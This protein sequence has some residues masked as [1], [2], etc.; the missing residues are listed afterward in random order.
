MLI[1]T[2]SHFLP[3]MD[4]GAKDVAESADLLQAIAAQGVTDLVS[5]AHFY[6][7]RESLDRFLER[8]AISIQELMR[9]ESITLNPP[10]SPFFAH[11]EGPSGSMR[12]HLGAEVALSSALFDQND[13][14]RL[15]IDR[16]PYMLIELPFTDRWDSNVRTQL[17]SLV[18]EYQLKPIIAHVERYP[19]SDY[20]RD[21]E[22]IR[23]LS[24]LPCLLQMNVDSL[25]RFAWK[26][27]CR[28][29]LQSQWIDLLGSDS[30]NMNQ[31]PPA[32]DTM[33]KFAKRW[34]L[35]PEAEFFVDLN[36]ERSTTV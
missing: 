29:L 19:A 25:R 9:L 23:K 36:E 7:K 26:K 18:Y 30:H 14:S 22:Q 33:R 13:L 24:E 3:H 17:E 4:D 5:T 2:H 21:L 6:P 31:R 8:R 10:E 27:R 12:L 28:I 34:D 32:F 35:K 20:G 15:C 1:D 11:Y 16:S